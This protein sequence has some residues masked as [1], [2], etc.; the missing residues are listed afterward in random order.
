MTFA[1]AIPAVWSS[2]PTTIA[3]SGMT[4][5]SGRQWRDWNGAVVTCALKGSQ[6]RVII[7][8]P[9]G[10]GTAAQTAVLTTFGRLRTPVQGPDGNLYL[11]TSNGGGHDQILRVTPS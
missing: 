10:R 2:G 8:T 11:T 7:L 3:T 6:V 1:G 5:L 9:D 4:F